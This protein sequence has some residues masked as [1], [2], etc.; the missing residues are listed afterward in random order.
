M[1]YEN[2]KQLPC[3][4]ANKIGESK[5]KNVIILIDAFITSFGQH[6]SPKTATQKLPFSLFSYA[7]QRVLLFS[8]FT[9]FGSNTEDSSV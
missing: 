4:Q 9:K 1:T 2:K 6:L 3:N 5:V 8:I 7:L